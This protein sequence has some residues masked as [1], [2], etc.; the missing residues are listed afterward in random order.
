M[1]I[2]TRPISEL[3]DHIFMPVCQQLSH[4]IL[5]ILGYAD[6]VGDNIYINTEWSAHSKTSNT[7]DVPNVNKN[8]LSIEAEVQMNPNQQ[9]WEAYTFKHTTAY[10][11]GKNLINSQEDIY[12]D[13]KNRVKVV[14][15]IS[16]VTI[17]L[18]CELVLTSSERAF[19]TP[20]QLF[21][22]YENG[23][24]ATYT[25]L[26]FDYSIPKPIVNVLVHVWKLDRDGGEPAGVSF[27]DYVK[28]R[29]D[30][31]WTVVKHKDL[32]EYELTVPRYNLKSLAALEYSG[33]KP[34]G[35]MEN[36]LATS[37]TIQ[38]TYTVQFGMPNMH[39]LQYPCVI[40]NQLIDGAY[41]PNDETI[42]F[43]EMP[44][45]RVDTAFQHYDM[46]ER[47]KHQE[48]IH[49][50]WYDDWDIPVTTKLHSDCYRPL[51]VMHILIDEVPGLYTTIDLREDA[52]E[53]YKLTPHIRMLLNN[54]GCLC[55]D[56]H[57]PVNVALYRDDTELLP[58]KD[59]FVDNNL[60]LSFKARDIYSHYRII[61]STI[62]EIEEV[63]P[64]F[65]Q[66]LLQ[67]FPY[68]P[69][70]LAR[71]LIDKLMRGSWS[72][73]VERLLNV[74]ISRTVLLRNGNLV[75]MVKHCIVGKVQDLY[76]L[77]YIRDIKCLDLDLSKVTV[78]VLVDQT[79]NTIYFPGMCVPKDGYI[80][81]RQQVL[82]KEVL[83]HATYK[84]TRIDIYTFKQREAGKFKTGGK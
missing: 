75:D 58:N 18:N 60:Q 83:N 39:I 3:T 14:E 8:R 17:N 57:A 48:Y 70:Y 78:D 41:I 42:R 25:D 62:N 10:G 46:S 23:T 30:N 20:L 34:T 7:N 21:N 31:G 12:H 19:Q 4:R 51:M 67:E 2:L 15:L 53:N 43:N 81:K 77:P 45:Y 38:F 27:I 66:V 36:K 68:L 1:P 28:R 52:D 22:G 32:D 9:K 59:F 71:S 50:P 24:V 56:R 76:I 13:D 69:F 54:E 49:L 44:E 40:Y 5:D 74:D 73:I 29:T 55:T 64:Q 65:F 6:V 26:F 80:E 16:P 35:N 84:D 82:S 61:I 33:D 11:L 79:T 72:K 63:R 37:Y 47:L